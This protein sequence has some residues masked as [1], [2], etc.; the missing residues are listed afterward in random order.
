MTWTLFFFISDYMMTVRQLSQILEKE[1]S[2]TKSILPDTLLL[3]KI[4]RWDARRNV[5]CLTLKSILTFQVWQR[6]NT[7]HEKQ[8]HEKGWPYF[9]YRISYR[10]WHR[11]PIINTTTNNKYPDIKTPNNNYPAL[12]APNKCIGRSQI[13]DLEEHNFPLL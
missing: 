13:V 11:R 5:N 2:G 1:G 6:Q 8:V 9:P 7:F 10:Y 4:Q 12:N 3:T